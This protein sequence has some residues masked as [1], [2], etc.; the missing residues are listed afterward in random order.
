M[1]SL[2]KIFE[3]LNSALREIRH[4]TTVKA[5]ITTQIT[6]FDRVR[7]FN[8]RFLAATI[9]VNQTLDKLTVFRYQI[10]ILNQ[11]NSFSFELVAHGNRTIDTPASFDKKLE[12]FNNNNSTVLSKLPTTRIVIPEDICTEDVIADEFI[13]AFNLM[14]LNI[15]NLE[16]MVYPERTYTEDVEDIEPIFSNPVLFDTIYDIIKA[17]FEEI[18]IMIYNDKASFRFSLSRIP[19]QECGFWMVGTI[20]CMEVYWLRPEFSYLINVSI[21]S[22]DK[23]TIEF[24]A[25]QEE[26]SKQ[27][28]EKVHEF[29]TRMLFKQKRIKPEDFNTKIVVDYFFEVL[30]D[31][32]TGYD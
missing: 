16:R 18:D 25:F 21:E 19:K 7:I 8:D 14:T 11:N 23:L 28:Y 9:I 15:Y 29:N 10:F 27:K 12:I 30:K 2:N 26:T 1:D 17:A 20:E 5:R 13:K 4:A 6:K 3:I 22:E 31:H 24:N 32:Q